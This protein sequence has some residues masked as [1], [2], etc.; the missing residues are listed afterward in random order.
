MWKFHRYL[1]V[2]RVEVARMLTICRELKSVV[3]EYRRRCHLE[4]YIQCSNA[5]QPLDHLKDI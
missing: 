4:T 5:F 2:S 3:Y 1:T